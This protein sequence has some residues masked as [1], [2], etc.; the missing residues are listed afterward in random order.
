MIT[1]DLLINQQALPELR[2][3]SGTAAPLG[4]GQIRAAVELYSLSANNITYATFGDALRYWQFFPSGEDGWG[5]VPVW[6]FARVVESQHDAVTVGERLYGFW[7]M[8]SHAV[9]TPDRISP[10]RLV[11]A[12]PHRA[13]LPAA[14]NAYFRCAADPLYTQGSEAVQALLRPLF[15][16][17]WLV[18]DFL[19][20][21]DFFGAQAAGAATV[22]LSS[23]SSKTA[24]GTA[25]CLAQRRGMRVIGLTSPRNQAFCERLGCYE[26]V[27]T[28]DALATLPADTPIV[29]VDFAGHAALTRAVHEHLRQLRFSLGVGFTHA[30]QPVGAEPPAL[31]GPPITFFFAPAQIKKRTT[32]WGAETFGQ[33]MAQAWHAFRQ[34]VSAPANPWLQVQE[35]RGTEAVGEVW[36][37]LHAGQGDPAVGHVVRA[38]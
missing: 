11:D 26:Q 7:P 4:P 15:I 16:T 31:P 30:D 33:R 34:H 13:D 14:Y 8:A 9:L 3:R 6:G 19:G 21:N 5:I 23:A 12:S 35:H 28:Y 27:L 25:F 17:S 1:T 20:D 32:E 10:Q 24:Y 36:R 38:D 18:D 37:A 2:A 29:Y 22:L